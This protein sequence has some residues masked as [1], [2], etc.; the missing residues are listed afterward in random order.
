[1]VVILSVSM[2]QSASSVISSPADPS[3]S[4]SPAMHG[5]A[6]NYVIL[7]WPGNL[8]L[9]RDSATL[10]TP[11]TSRERKRIKS[12]PLSMLEVPVRD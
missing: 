9:E 12:E 2:A 3:L 10:S 1:M 5:T 4:V 7:S 6:P 8:T 11:P